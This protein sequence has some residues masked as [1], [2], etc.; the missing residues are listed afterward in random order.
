MG[1]S[2]AYLF[3]ELAILIYIVGF[4]WEYCRAARLNSRA[5][6][7]TALFLAGVWFTLDQIAIHLGLW[8]FPTGGSLPLRFAGLPVEE[9][10]IFF[11]H[12]IICLV[13]LKKYSKTNNNK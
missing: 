12:T 6:L 4:G 3:L 2:S 1:S 13:L 9:Y 11:L 7:L 10:L 8:T 5:S